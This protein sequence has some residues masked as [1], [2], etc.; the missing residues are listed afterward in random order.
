MK[1][2]VLLLLL[3]SYLLSSGQNQGPLLDSLVSQR[4]ADYELSGNI[5]IATQGKIVYNRSAGLANTVTGKPITADASFHLASVSKT[6]TS[7]AI[8]QL[9]DKRKLKLDDPVKKYIPELNNNVI[10]IRQLL[11]HTAGLADLQVLEKPYAQDTSKIFTISDIPSAINNDPQAFRSAPG[12]RW[13]YSNS[14]YCLL[15][16]VV[17]KISKLPFQD[18]LRQN[19]FI[20]AGMAH[21]YVNTSLIAVNDPARAVG[22]DYPNYAPWLLQ[23]ADSLPRNHIELVHL[24]GLLGLANIVSTTTD[25][26]HF[27]RALYSGKIIKQSSLDEAFTPTRLTNGELAASG[28]K[29]NACYYGLGWMILRD[30]TYGKV[31]FHSGGMPGAVTMFIRNIT[32]DQTV[33]VLNNVTHRSTHG[34]A[35]SLLYLLNGG[36]PQTDKKSIAH[37]FSRALV[38]KGV[39]AAWTTFNVI[40]ADTTHFLL[41]EREMNIAGLG[42]F[43]NGYQTA[44]IEVLRLNTVLFP[45]S[46]NVYDSYASVLAHLGRKQEAIQMYQKTL[47]L[48][49]TAAGASSALKKLEATLQQ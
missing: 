5:L 38:S 47:A 19:I 11:S 26:L 48:N 41:D 21:T 4:V 44:G 29:N 28:W 34:T 12:E 49:P 25:L 18:Y 40:K 8:L 1:K 9:R 45:H 2:T 35:M 3:F 42:M 14:G 39:D 20:P 27:D 22:Y 13:S 10:T 24:N 7:V 6:F 37:A 16:L 33:I 17:E 23:R 36:T 15:A 31:V 30:S 46:S 32:K 43:Y